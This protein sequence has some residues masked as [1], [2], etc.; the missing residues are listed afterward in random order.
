MS[1]RLRVLMEGMGLAES[2]RWHAGAVFVADWTGGLIYRTDPE[3]GASEVVA[4]LRSFPLCFDFIADGD[5]LVL[6]G[7]EEAVLRQDVNGKLT[8]V[9]DLKG[10]AAGGWNELLVGPSGQTWA[11]VGNFDPRRGLP[12]PGSRSGMIVLTS[13]PVP[14]VVA[15]GLDFPNGMALTPDGTE[16]V[17]AESHASK[18]T[19][20]PIE[21]DGVLG[22]A[23]TWAATPGLHPDGIAMDRQGRCWI[24]DVGT[25]SVALVAEGGEII[26]QVDTGDGAFSCALDE[27]GSQLFVATANWAD[28]RG[29][30]DPHH[31]WRG[32]LLA[33]KVAS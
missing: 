23:R 29:F 25:A 9:A 19:A 10:L 18:L 26:Q 6:S 12:A 28:G 7:A 24:A 20:Y 32:R 33:L 31:D 17:V 3:S 30:G 27:T 13:Q 5:L 1:K 4:R 21:S 2:V 16:L 14:R 11:N 8:A 15:D 22:P